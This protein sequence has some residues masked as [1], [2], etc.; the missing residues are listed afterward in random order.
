[1][2]VASAWD[3]NMLSTLVSHSD[4]TFSAEEATVIAIVTSN[5]TDEYM[6]LTHQCYWY[7][8]IIFNTII[9]MQMYCT[10]WEKWL[11]DIEVMKKNF[12]YTDSW[13]VE[14]GE[15]IENCQK[16]KTGKVEER[17]FLPSTSH[18]YLMQVART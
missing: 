13:I 16:R 11:E 18:N 3:A 1:M 8:Q 6:P 17:K 14:E 12:T 15:A 2:P 10:K 9:E 5:A 7:A 4:S